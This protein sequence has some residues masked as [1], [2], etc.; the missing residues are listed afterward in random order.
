MF[1]LMLERAH[2]KEGT[3]LSRT[4]GESGEGTDLLQY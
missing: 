3:F 2:L 4:Q 1:E